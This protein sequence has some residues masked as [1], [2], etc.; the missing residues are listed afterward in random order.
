MDKEFEIEE[1]KDIL[2]NKEQSG[3]SHIKKVKMIT[4][5]PYKINYNVGSLMS[6]DREYECIGEFIN[7]ETGE[8][9][10]VLRQGKNFMSVVTEKSN[11][12]FQ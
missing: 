7:Y 1:L 3:N 8:D 9:M 4:Y 11:V 5:V 2:S 10:V 12:V 6:K